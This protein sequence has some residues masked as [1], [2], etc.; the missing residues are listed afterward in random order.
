M[1]S[2][3]GIF[4]TAG[5]Q[6]IERLMTDDGAPGLSLIADRVL[7]GGCLGKVI[8]YCWAARLD[9]LDNGG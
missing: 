2:R 3:I 8:G 4:R 5:M 7:A 6:A 1:G 9:R